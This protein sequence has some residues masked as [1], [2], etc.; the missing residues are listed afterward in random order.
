MATTRDLVST[1]AP[2]KSAILIPAY[3]LSLQQLQIASYSPPESLQI[4]MTDPIA[5]PAF[6]D[7]LSITGSLT[8]QRATLTSSPAPAGPAGLFTPTRGSG[9]SSRVGA[10][11]PVYVQD[12]NSIGPALSQ[13]LQFQ[14]ALAMSGGAGPQAQPAA[15]A[16]PAQPPPAA[17]AT[18]ASPTR[19]DNWHIKPDGCIYQGPREHSSQVKDIRGNLVVTQSGRWY[20]LGQPDDGIRG[21]MAQVLPAWDWP[22]DPL[23]PSCRQALLLAETIVYGHAS[24]KV[25]ALNVL[26]RDLESDLSVFNP[27]FSGHFAMVRQLHR[28]VGLAV[29]LGQTVGSAG[30]ATVHALGQPSASG[31]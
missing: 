3:L 17:T 10:S 1:S 11:S 29:D 24:L 28:S 15:S 13:Q 6:I 18:A 23:A 8:Q 9:A 31:P 19:I 12:P 5:A 20:L 22:R 30:P 26:L 14:N 21:V 25:K 2:G 7:D 27:Q 4:S 16:Q